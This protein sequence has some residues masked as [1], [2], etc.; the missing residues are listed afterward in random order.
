MVKR[1]IRCLVGAALLLP[2]VL[3]TEAPGQVDRF[4]G[5]P[6][7]L[8]S[9][10]IYFTSWKYVRQ[11][12]FVWRI[13]RDSDA[14]EADEDVGAWLAGDGTRPARFEV[15]DMPDGIRL[16]AQKAEK[17][18]F[19]PGQIAAQVFDRG[20]YK[21]WYT[22]DPCAEAE[23]QS[24]KDKIL[25]GHNAHVC[26]AESD[27]A[28]KWEIPK[29]GLYQY[30]GTKDNNAVFRGDANGSVRGFHGVG[31]QA[32]RLTPWHLDDLNGER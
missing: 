2:A 32:R 15:S 23:P 12:S 13:E 28:V 10:F 27:D 3:V 25:P 16:V 9:N 21:T 31:Y 11:G 8:R 22:I 18:P 5:E 30:A 1:S 4:Y 26:Y 17:V 20:K 6:V 24:T 7:E 29:L 19:Q 14:T